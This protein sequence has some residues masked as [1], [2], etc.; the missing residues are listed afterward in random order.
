ML[1]LKGL[2]Q[3]RG[4]YNVSSPAAA[5]AR[6]PRQGTSASRAVSST[7]QLHGGHLFL[8]YE[9]GFAPM[10]MVALELG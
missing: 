5:D 9:I 6:S 7:S 1:P 10:V 3:L 4:E 2:F 8:L